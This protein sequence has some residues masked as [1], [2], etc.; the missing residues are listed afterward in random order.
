[1]NTNKS[2]TKRKGEEGRDQKVFHLL[3]SVM[4]TMGRSQKLFPVAHVCAARTS[5]IA[6][7]S[8]LTG[9]WIRNG[10]SGPQTT[11]HMEYWHHTEQLFLL[12]HNGGPEI[13][14]F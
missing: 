2:L 14:Y 8:A 7:P 6:L 11:A 1:M 4:A 10:V 9:S 5:S 12:S 13:P 3:F